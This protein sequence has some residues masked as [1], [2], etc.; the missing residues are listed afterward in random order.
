MPDKPR[1][2][3]NLDNTHLLNARVD[4]L[5]H[6]LSTR[7]ADLLASQSGAR[8]RR[9]ESGAQRLE[10][11]LWGKPLWVSLPEG[12]IETPGSSTPANIAFTALVLYYLT[13]ADGAPTGN[14][15]L[16]FSE[17]PDGRFYTQAFQG[18]TGRLMNDRFRADPSRFAAAAMAADGK[19][20]PFGDLAFRFTLLPR[21][22]LLVVRWEGDEEFPANH[23]ILFSSGV[24]HYLPTDSCAIAGSML[25]R[26]ILAAA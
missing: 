25:T 5:R 15:W 8:L 4:E 12:L 16:A 17:L 2:P 22:D 21:V 3:V 1:S 6:E 19:S 14:E 26:K 9:S 24:S 23:Q 11:A 7:P 18:Y 13:H 10:L 20:T